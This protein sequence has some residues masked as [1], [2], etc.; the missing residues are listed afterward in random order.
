MSQPAALLQLQEIE[1]AIVA[2]QQ[3]IQ[4][5]DD[6][7]ANDEAVNAAQTA[8][9]QAEDA[10]K[11]MNKRARELELDIEATRTK[12][13]E[14]EAR[15]YSGNVKNPKE[16]QEMQQEVAALKEKQS[17]LEDET[18]EL[19]E[20][21]EAAEAALQQHKAELEQVLT[22]R[23]HQHDA[24]RV[25][26]DHKTGELDD[27]QAKRAQTIDKLDA[28][29]LKL[30]EQLKAR[31]RRLPVARMKNDGICGLCGV[32]Q[33]RATESAVR[34]GDLTQCTNCRRILV[35]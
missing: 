17:D 34:R 25:E 24:L 5:I 21:I 22:S 4:E 20:Q 8:V 29:S 33:D 10:L 19:M 27:L 30:Y 11:P 28:K 31:L 15:L 32:Q 2:T 9:T 3:R 26:R 7:L 16:M 23:G 12:A 13:E 35:F 6:T 14:T 1:Q 18:L